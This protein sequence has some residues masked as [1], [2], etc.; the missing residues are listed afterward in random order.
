MWLALFLA[1]MGDTIKWIGSNHF[2]L[3]PFEHQYSYRISVWL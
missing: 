2:L 3:I 1:K